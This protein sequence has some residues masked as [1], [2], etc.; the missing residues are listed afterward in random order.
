MTQA[1]KAVVNGPYNTS[2]ASPYSRPPSAP[3]MS[4][5]VEIPEDEFKKAT[6]LELKQELAMRILNSI[7]ADL[8]NLHDW[9]NKM[10]VV[11]RQEPHP[12]DFPTIL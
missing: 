3:T 10:R 7:E 2:L 4:C 11:L 8:V 9:Q 6:T 1:F 5:K 12:W